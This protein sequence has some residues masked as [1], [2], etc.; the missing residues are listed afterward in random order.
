MKK[1]ILLFLFIIALPKL[2]FAEY[3]E[4][5]GYF[6][7]KYTVDMV[8]HE[9]NT[10]DVTENIDAV[11][12]IESRGIFRMIP[13]CVWVKRDVSE[14]QDGS[15]TRMMKYWVNVN[16]ATASETWSEMEDTG[17]SI[18]GMRLGKSDI[19]LSGP[20][21]Y[22]I[23]YQL[24]IYGDR[25]PQSDLFFY[26]VLGSGWS[27]NTN[28]FK[29]TIHFDKPLTDKEVNSL[30]VF[31][32]NERS[33]TSEKDV[34]ADI[35]YD[36]NRTDI[37]GGAKNIPPYSAITV[38]IPLHEGYYTNGTHPGME[39][40]LT[41]IF[42]VLSLLLLLYILYKEMFS[43]QE[44]TKIISFYPPKGCTSLDVG[45]LID[46]TVDD[47]DVIS[48]IPWFAQKG[49]LTIDNTGTHPIL[50]KVKDLPSDAPKYLSTLFEGFF[51]NGD[52]FSLGSVNQKFGAAWLNTK[53]LA[54]KSFKDKL[55]E[56]DE[57]TVV[58]LLLD[59]FFVCMA[60]CWATNDH[61][62]WI[63]G[64]IASVA[65]A[66]AVAVQISYGCSS[67]NKK[68][69]WASAFVTAT[70]LLWNFSMIYIMF[71]QNTDAWLI[72]DP[73]WL[74]VANIG[75]GIACVFSS[76]LTYMTEYRRTRIGEILGL[77]EFISTA[78]KQQL[79]NLQA[80]DEKYFYNILPYAVAFGMAEQWAKRF[81]GIKVNPV[82][83][84]KGTNNNI[85]NLADFS[86]HRMFSNGIQSS[87]KS[88]QKA[89]EAAA[90]ANSSHGSSYSSSG[91]HSSGG[92]S[93]GGF[94]GGG[95][96]R[97]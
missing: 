3:E 16:N 32:G 23:K 56:V 96:G 68:D 94:G 50:H 41:N 75:V 18:Y 65:Y 73:T 26:S 83:W 42:I 12:T 69:L 86:T 74:Y 4:E 78:D 7:E 54:K 72:N 51:K 60:T 63:L 81:A 85:T 64:G 82:D 24:E 9:N 2:A 97:W 71:A 20:H 80:E 76:K 10:I 49:Y 46:T 92:Y 90:A 13:R 22:T 11:F 87:I 8:V 53:S 91:S 15:K 14:A 39:I 28:S 66:I 58:L 62:G 5:P 17:D 33:T 31:T 57:Y 48:L 59:I 55:N 44:I 38:F 37:S 19:W 93:G 89:R 95:G 43:K 27:C 88:E 47:Q 45:T 34:S 35:L 61:D 84:Y 52:T 21:S 40:M 6:F 67:E 70:C 36:L 1:I 25:V 30:K 79:E 29:F 77:H